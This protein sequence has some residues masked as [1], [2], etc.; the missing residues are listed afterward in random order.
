MGDFVRCCVHLRV[1]RTCHTS[2]AGALAEKKVQ[3]IC[4]INF[5]TRICTKNCAWICTYACTRIC[6]LRAVMWAL[7][8]A[9]QGRRTTSV[10]NSVRQLPICH[11]PY[12]LWPS[13]YQPL[14]NYSQTK[15]KKKKKE[16]KKRG[17]DKGKEENKEDKRK[18]GRK[19]GR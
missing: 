1:S 6:S 14:I 12:L 9:A 3:R 10:I 19:E 5:T 18:E 4:A 7:R 16:R 17:R 2:A 15:K 11:Q 8:R 13:I